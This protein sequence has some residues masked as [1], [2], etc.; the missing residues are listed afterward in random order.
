MDEQASITADTLELMLL[1]Q[2]AIRAALE[3]LSLWVS[4][5]GSVHVHENVMGVLA[6]LDSHVEGITSGIERLR[7]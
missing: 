2:V 1:N 5:R 6:T 7:E 4:H 3:E